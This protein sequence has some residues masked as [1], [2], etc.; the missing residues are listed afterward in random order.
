MGLTGSFLNGISQT[1]LYVALALYGSAIGLSSGSIGSLI[2]FMALG[3]MIC[4]FLL[5]KLSDLVDRRLVL[6][7]APGIAIPLCSSLRCWKI[8]PTT[9]FDSI[10]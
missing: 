6:V 10:A 7:G 8:Q 9:W 4:Q 5:G 2:G 1:V 3:G